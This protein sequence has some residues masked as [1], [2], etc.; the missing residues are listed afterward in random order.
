MP[1]PLLFASEA[2][3]R[4]RKVRPRARDR[5]CEEEESEGG[6]PTMSKYCPIKA[7]ATEPADAGCFCDGSKCAWFE[8]GP[9]QKCAILSIA[10]SLRVLTQLTSQPKLT[11]QDYRDQLE[12]LR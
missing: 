10:V 1:R 11:S 8:D 12:A 6:V 2:R 3:G 9:V 4:T 7:C 5:G